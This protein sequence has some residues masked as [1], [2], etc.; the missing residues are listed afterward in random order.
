MSSP[1]K[2]EAPHFTAFSPCG[3]HGASPSLDIGLWEAIVDAGPPLRIP[4]EACRGL[5][6]LR[7]RHSWRFI[8]R[9][10]PKEIADRRLGDAV[11]LA[12]VLG[13]NVAWISD[14]AFTIVD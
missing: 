12:S 4:T 13:K 11:E 3:V 8:Y 14:D 2:P 6:H 10:F 5:A 1:L 7:A 9:R